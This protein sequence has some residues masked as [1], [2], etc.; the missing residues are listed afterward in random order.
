MGES[1]IM[2]QSIQDAS[3]C[4]PQQVCASTADPERNCDES[5]VKMASATVVNAGSEAGSVAGQ[6]NGCLHRIRIATYKPNA[7]GFG[8]KNLYCC[9]YYGAK[10]MYCGA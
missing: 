4:L 5:P 10:I 9:R 3:G 6:A 2:S 1:E 8:A 7:V